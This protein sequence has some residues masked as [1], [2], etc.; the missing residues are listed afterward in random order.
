MKQAIQHETHTSAK[1]LKSPHW[2]IWSCTLKKD[3]VTS[4]IWV[5]SSAGI[6]FKRNLEALRTGQ[7]R[8]GLPTGC[9]CEEHKKRLGQYCAKYRIVMI[10]ALSFPVPSPFKITL[11]EAPQS[12]G[13]LGAPI[14]WSRDD[15]VS[16]CWRSKV[17]F[18][19]FEKPLSVVL[20]LNVILCCCSLERITSAWALVVMCHPR[21]YIESI[22]W[23]PLRFL[24]A[25]AEIRSLG[26]RRRWSSSSAFVAPWHG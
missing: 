22:G 11:I 23:P 6:I 20:L 12:F 16:L 4:Q 3:L 9:P 15:A 14:Q 18:F 5:P 21:C 17:T 26:I 10:T 19:E 8:F 1:I 2:D 7:K 24:F 25:A 13:D